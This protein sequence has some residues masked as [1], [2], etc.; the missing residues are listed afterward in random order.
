MLYPNYVRGQ[1]YVKLRQGK[2][3]A[4]EFQKPPDHNP[5]RKLNFPKLGS[6]RRVARIGVTVSMRFLRRIQECTCGAVFAAGGGNNFDRKPDAGYQ[7][8]E[9]ISLL[10]NV[11]TTGPL[12]DST[13]SVPQRSHRVRFSFMER[14]F[15]FHRCKILPSIPENR[16]WIEEN[17][18][19][20]S[21]LY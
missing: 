2:E 1:A 21:G 17:W 18:T 9:F 5:S 12:C 14:T 6:P 3:A 8:I 7:S 13:L 15:L 10:E 4:A 11:D 16:K 20:T 19:D